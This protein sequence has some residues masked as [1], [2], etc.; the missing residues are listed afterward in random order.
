MRELHALP[1]T[2]RQARSPLE[3]AV[4]SIVRYVP[5]FL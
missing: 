3:S 1:G 4:A 2:G 5:S